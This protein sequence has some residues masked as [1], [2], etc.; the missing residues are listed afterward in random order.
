MSYFYGHCQKCRIFMGTVKCIFIGTVRNV[1]FLWTL[2]EMSYFY[3]HCQNVVFL[4][5]LSEMYFY[6]NSEMSYFYNLDKSGTLGARNQIL[7]DTATQLFKTRKTGTVP[8]ERA[9]LASIIVGLLTAQHLLHLYMRHNTLGHHADAT[10][11]FCTDVY[12]NFHLC[13]SSRNVPAAT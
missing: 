11:S 2:S 4:S 13:Y 12:Y 7:R 8:W 1:E 6:G 3:G 5:T 9:R 10:T